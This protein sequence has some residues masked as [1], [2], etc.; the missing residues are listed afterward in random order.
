M[1]VGRRISRRLNSN[2]GVR[3]YLSP[4]KWIGST[5]AI[6]HMESRQ[7]AGVISEASSH[8][9]GSKGE[10]VRLCCRVCVGVTSASWSS[11]HE[12]KHCVTLSCDDT[13]TIDFTLVY[14]MKWPRPKSL[15]LKKIEDRR[16]ALLYVKWLFRSVVDGAYSA[17]QFGL[18]PNKHA[19]SESAAVGEK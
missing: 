19:P 11:A 18:R 7:A 10:D 6:H 13:L 15:R 16:L 17:E 14:I 9:K 5:R 4:I 1:I 8:L 3:S 12:A 2:S